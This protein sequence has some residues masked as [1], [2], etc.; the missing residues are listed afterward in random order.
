MAPP[1]IAPAASP[2]TPDRDNEISSAASISPA[3]PLSQ[4][5]VESL[6]TRTIASEPPPPCS[7]A[8]ER[9][10]ATRQPTVKGIAMMSQ[11]AM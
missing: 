10:R 3:D 9:T 4:K 6:R 1:T 8:L 5:T 2:T 11:V 7:P